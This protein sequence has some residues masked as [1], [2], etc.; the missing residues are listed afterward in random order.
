MVNLKRTSEFDLFDIT[1]CYK[2]LTLG[3]FS[4]IHP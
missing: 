3:T 1:A 4:N 2:I